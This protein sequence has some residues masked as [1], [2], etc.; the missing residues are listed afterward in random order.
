MGNKYIQGMKSAMLD[1][2]TNYTESVSYYT[3]TLQEKINSVGDYA[4]DNFKIDE[5]K[6]AG[7]FEFSPIVCRICNAISPKTG[8]NLGDDFKDLKFLDLSYKVAM[9]RRYVFSDSVWITINTDAY[10]Y[11]T[12]SAIVRRCN[13]ELRWI[14]NGEIVSE[15]CILGYTLKYSNIYYNDS[16]DI[17][18]GTLTITTQYN[19]NS[20]KIKINDRFILGS[21][22]FKIKSILDSLRQK[23]FDKDS[24]PTID[25]EVYI[26][27]KAPDDDFDIQVANMNRYKD[28]P[29]IP[30]EYKSEIIISPNSLEI[31]QGETEI[32]SCY[33]Y[34]NGEKQDLEFSFIDSNIPIENYEFNVIDGN[35]FSIYNKKYYKP[36]KLVVKC[37]S[38]NFVQEFSFSLK[39][40]Y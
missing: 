13:N 5:E 16:V 21:S 25:F 9:G 18:Q 39:G 20:K 6:I 36:K 28:S 27:N 32:Y 3:R 15:P 14:E 38:M 24:P 4:S 10:K 29:I 22:V 30:T 11:I 19:K 40:V 23:T 1:T 17:P 2:P 31:L 12:P 34:I 26:D 8:H 37:I 33:L 7:T 35:S